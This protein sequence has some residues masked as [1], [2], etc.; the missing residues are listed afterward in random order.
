MTFPDWVRHV[1]D[2]PVTDPAWHWDI[3]VD[4]SEPPASKSVEYQTELF[5]SPVRALA[6][7]SDA[8]IN[9]GLWYLV[10][11][12]CSDYM[13]ALIEPGVAWDE[14]RRRD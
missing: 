13:F 4:T 7:Y 2:H 14:R 12:S 8:Q 10:S 3:D 6:A 11:N 9:Q 1:F 5:Q